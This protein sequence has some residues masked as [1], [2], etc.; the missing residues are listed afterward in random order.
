MEDLKETLK[1]TLGVIPEDKLKSTREYVQQ[2]ISLRLAAMGVDMD[3]DDIEE[4]EQN[5]MRILKGLLSNYKEREALFDIIVEKAVD[6]HIA[7]GTLEE[8]E[9]HNK[10]FEDYL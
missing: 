1:D 9:E 8:I 7:F 3:S 10:G 5:F 4:S 2:Y 6:Y